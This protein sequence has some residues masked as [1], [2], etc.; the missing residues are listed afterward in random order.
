MTKVHTTIT[1]PWSSAPKETFSHS[2]EKNKQDFGK[3]ENAERMTKGEGSG[4]V[5]QSWAL[6]ADEAKEAK[7]RLPAT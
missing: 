7:H 3:V 2:N 1:T 5:M 6:R 4:V